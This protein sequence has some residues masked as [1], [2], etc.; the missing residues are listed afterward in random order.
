[1][2]FGAGGVW[3]A[4]PAGPCLLGEKGMGLLGRSP[5]PRRPWRGPLGGGIA[6]PLGEPP[7]GFFA[8]FWRHPH[9]GEGAGRA[10]GSGGG[11]GRRAGSGAGRWLRVRPRAVGARAAATAVSLAPRA[12]GLE[13]AVLTRLGGRVAT[14]PPPRTPWPLPSS[15]PKELIFFAL[16][17]WAGLD[18]GKGLFLRVVVQFRLLGTLA[19][20]SRL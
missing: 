7:R 5:S 9:V 10:R 16:K 12:C 15:T 1:M 19:W 20:I 18:S 2:Q 17:S 3:L 6:P 13:E 8:E 4:A 14:L 11:G